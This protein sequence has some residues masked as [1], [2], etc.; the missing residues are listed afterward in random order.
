MIRQ[1]A[2]TPGPTSNNL[3]PRHHPRRRRCRRR[4]RR[5][6]HHRRRHSQGIFPFKC[7]HPHRTHPE[8]LDGDGD[9][10]SLPYR[11]VHISVLAAA[12]LVLHHDVRPADSVNV[13]SLAFTYNHDLLSIII[14]ATFM[15]GCLTIR[16]DDKDCN[17][18]D[19]QQHY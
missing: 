15:S 4:H 18:D 10:V 1:P 5:R 6:R 11:L 9:V 8:R 12:Q 3:L 2:P 7:D 16:N 19:H 14:V 17:D 13:S